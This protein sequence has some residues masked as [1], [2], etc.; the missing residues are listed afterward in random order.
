MEQFWDFKSKNYP[1]PMEE[2][3]LITPNRVLK[4]VKE[5]GVDFSN[6]SVLDI[7][8]GTGLYSS[9]ISKDASSILGVDLS[10]GMLGRFK[11]YID[12]NAIDNIRLIKEDFKKFNTDEQYDIV[13]S[14]MTP[15]ISSIEDLH[16]MMNLSKKSCIF[17]SFSKDRHSPIM[18]DIMKLL[19]YEFEGTV[20]KFNMTKEYLNS[21]GYETKE[22]FF[23]HNWTQEGTIEE[24]AKDVVEHLKLKDMDISIDEAIE[25]LRPYEKEGKVI[26]ETFSSIGVLVWDIA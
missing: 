9:I 1:T 2:E 15:A 5:F 21:L 10:S 20:N 11:E 16:T 3:G 22:E 12:K 4:R 6:K 18:D 17:V 19:G 25:F 13:L 8:C 14:A 23:E 26:R 7:G 24:I